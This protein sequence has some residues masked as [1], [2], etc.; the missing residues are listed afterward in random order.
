MSEKLIEQ[1]T[2]DLKLLKIEY[3][4]LEKKRRFIVKTNGLASSE[5]AIDVS[6][7][8]T[9]PEYREVVYK[10]SLLNGKITPLKHELYQL[11]QMRKI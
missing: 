5:K 1:Y 6:P 8:R 9:T 7:L 4:K 11:T 10:M 2:Y 3:R